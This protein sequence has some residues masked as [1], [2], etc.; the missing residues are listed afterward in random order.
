MQEELALKR[1]INRII[2]PGN[3]NTA[4]FLQQ[5]IFLEIGKRGFAAIC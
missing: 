3:S 5:V 1:E 4:P 2:E